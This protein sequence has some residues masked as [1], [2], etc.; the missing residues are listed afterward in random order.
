MKRNNLTMLGHLA[1]LRKRLTII[2]IANLILTFICYEYSNKLVQLFLDMNKNMRLVYLTPP[3]LFLAYLKIS[4]I[5][6]VIIASP[7]TILQI[8]IFISPGLYKKERAGIIG[9]FIAGLLFF[10]TGGLFA[11]KVVLPTMLE[12]FQKFQTEEIAQ[13]IS[14]G[15]YLDFVLSIIFTFGIVF[16]M[17]VLAALLA[18]LKLIKAKTLKKKQPV[19]ILIIFIIAAIMT[20][21]DIVSQIMLAVPMILLLQ[22]SIGICWLINKYQED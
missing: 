20:P 2:V 18:K 16:E 11:Y 22:L 4:L 15:S 17:P 6:G 3:E 8:W 7:I 19:M 12:F 1:E 9:T 5:A 10:M 14:V 13:M 21:P